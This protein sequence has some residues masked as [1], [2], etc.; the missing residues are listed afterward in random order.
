MRHSDVRSHSEYGDPLHSIKKVKDN[1]WSGSI[2]MLFCFS[3]LYIFFTEGP[4]NYDPFARWFLPISLISLFCLVGLRFLRDNGGLCVV[5]YTNGVWCNNK[6]PGT[7]NNFIPWEYI[8]Y[9]EKLRYAVQFKKYNY[10]V[11]SLNEKQK[12]NYEKKGFKNRIDSFLLWPHNKPFI[13]ADALD[14]D[15]DKLLDLMNQ[16]L[17]RVQTQRSAARQRSRTTSRRE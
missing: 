12:C 15:V 5:I 7:P 8:D 2:T 13:L 16:E 4:E 10:I 3:C 17:S 14:I 6:I 9:I 1:F 11:F